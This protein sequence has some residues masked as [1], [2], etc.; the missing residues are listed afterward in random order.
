MNLLP[1]ETTQ[2]EADPAV[3]CVVKDEVLLYVLRF[4]HTMFCYL[5]IVLCIVVN[6]YIVLRRPE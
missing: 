5:Y 3:L 4:I 2:H 6:K 1:N